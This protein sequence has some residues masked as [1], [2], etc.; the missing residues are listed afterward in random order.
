VITSFNITR[1]SLPLLALAAT[2]KRAKADT[3]DLSL[4]CDTAFAP[5]LRKVAAAYR[6]KTSAEVFVFPT[7]PGLILPQLERDIQNDI[8]ATQIAI[9]EQLQQARIIAAVPTAP[10]WR[11]PLVIAGRS[12]TAALD[13]TFTAP[14]PTPAFAID[15]PALVAKL[16]L[17][18]AR[19]L[20]TVNTREVASLLLSGVA[21]AGLVHMTDVRAN[22]GLA[23]IRPV[24]P[25]IQPPAVYAASVTRLSSRP[26]PQGFI[27]FLA[28]PEATA[29]LAASGLETQ[30]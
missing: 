5:A 25:E 24:P 17:K 8:V 23:V 21:Q 4:A 16:G 27:A 20:G 13:Q 15:G 14:D 12:A 26:D 3:I 28:T 9:L 29:L 18:P 22:P 11:T 2:M 1:R 19:L 10:R 7:G 6:V 30:P